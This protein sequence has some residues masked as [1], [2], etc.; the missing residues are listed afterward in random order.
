MLYLCGSESARSSTDSCSDC[1]QFFT[2]DKIF[3]S[4][5][6]RGRKDKLVLDYEKEGNYKRK[7]TSESSKFSED[8]YSM[9]VKCPFRLRSTPSGSGWKVMVRFGFHNHKLSE[10]LDDHDILDRLKVH[11]RQF[12]NDVTKYNMVL[13]YIIYVLKDKDPRNLTSVTQV[14]KARVTYNANKIGSLTKMKMLLSLIHREKYMCW[15][16]NRKDSNVVADIF[17]THSDSVK[18][19]NMFWC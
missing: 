14:Y 13:R 8:T 11:E 4:R 7:N 5:S 10:D 12:V 18:L 17:W 2:T 3:E 16:R 15:T 9:K 6:E 1:T 19:L